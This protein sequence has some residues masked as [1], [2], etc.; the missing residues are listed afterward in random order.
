[1]NITV[2]GLGNLLYGDEGFG[3]TMAE[4]L[5]TGHSW[6]ESV[7]IV[8]GGTQG[9]Y[10]LD[11]IESAEKL[12]IIDAVI[13]VEEGLKVHVFRN[14]IPTKIQKKMSSHQTGLSELLAMA[15]LHN[16]LPEDLVLVGIPPVNLEMGIG[17]SPE[18]QAL[19]PEVISIVK[20]II[21]GWSEE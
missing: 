18:I 9:L 2:L 6:P 17:L 4:Q 7:T 15:K 19:V 8:D 13:P 20:S 11:Y 10:L 16:H 14:E 12:I 21:R 5:R 3:C 1:M